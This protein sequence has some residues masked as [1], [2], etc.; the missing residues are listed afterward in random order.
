MAQPG[1][2]KVK[3]EIN[4]TISDKFNDGCDSIE[5]I[6]DDDRYTVNVIKNDMQILIYHLYDCQISEIVK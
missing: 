4:R 6:S 5:I 2:E 3:D 1:S